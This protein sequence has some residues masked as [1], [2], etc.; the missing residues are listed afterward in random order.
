M[1]KVYGKGDTLDQYCYAME[2][3]CNE[4]LVY[5]PQCKGD[6]LHAMRVLIKEIANLKVE[7][8]RLMSDLNTFTRYN[9]RTESDKDPIDVPGDGPILALQIHNGYVHATR[10]TDGKAITWVA[11]SGMWKDTLLWVQRR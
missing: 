7:Q 8:A 11:V 4:Q 9:G 3:D 2:Q 5:T 10:L 1:H 6:I